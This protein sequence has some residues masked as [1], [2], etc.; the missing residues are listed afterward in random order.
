MQ[1]IVI[2]IG[3][4]LVW[5]FGLLE[6]LRDTPNMIFVVLGFVGLA[7]WLRMQ[8]KFNKEAANNP[9]QIK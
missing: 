2:P 3:D 8:I 1:D 4:F 6:W 7:I 5:S 9:N